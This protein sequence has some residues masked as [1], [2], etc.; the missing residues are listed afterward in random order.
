MQNVQ[1]FFSNDIFLQ[2]VRKQVL[3]PW[4]ISDDITSAWIQLGVWKY[5]AF[6]TLLMTSTELQ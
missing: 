2:N 6:E 5:K 3:A 1:T 4:L